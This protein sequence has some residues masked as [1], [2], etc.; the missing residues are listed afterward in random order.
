MNEYKAKKVMEILEKVIKINATKGTDLVADLRGSSLYV[1]D[2]NNDCKSIIDYEGITSHI[3]FTKHWDNYFDG[4]AE[5]MH[6]ALD[7]YLEV[8]NE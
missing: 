7:K 5:A 2:T 1:Y 4:M 3:Y 6:E 8:N